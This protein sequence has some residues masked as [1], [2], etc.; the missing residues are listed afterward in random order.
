MPQIYD[1]SFFMRLIPQLLAMLLAITSIAVPCVAK[2]Q[3]DNSNSIAQVSVEVD[4]GDCRGTCIKAIVSRQDDLDQTII[5]QKLSSGLS[6]ATPQQTRFPPAN[7]SA[8]FKPPNA[9]C[10]SPVNLYELC[11]QLN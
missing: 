5:V 2:T 11:R 9:I 3:T 10:A 7:L 8:L 4:D 6:T 1:R